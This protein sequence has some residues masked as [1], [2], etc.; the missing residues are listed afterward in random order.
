MV[1]GAI[2][3][4]LP[5][6]QDGVKYVRAGVMLTGITPKGSSELLDAFVPVHDQRGIGE[7]L[8]KVGRRYGAGNIGLGLAGVKAA[9]I[10]SMKR[11]KLS[12]RAT[13]HWDELAT[14]HAR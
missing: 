10:W 12:K 11:D 4:L 7:L 3:A 14:V 5:R 1:K 9:P 8:D 13:T 2:A 6:I